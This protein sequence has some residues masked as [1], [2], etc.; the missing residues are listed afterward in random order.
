MFNY[1]DC[2]AMFDDFGREKVML[3]RLL[4]G[5]PWWGSWRKKQIWKERIQWLEKIKEPRLWLLYLMA[6]R[7]RILQQ[8][9]IKMMVRFREKSL[10]KHADTDYLP[11]QI[12]PMMLTT[13]VND[14]STDGERHLTPDEV[15][16]ELKDYKKRLQAK[17]GAKTLQEVLAMYLTNSE[18]ERKDS[19]KFSIVKKRLR[20]LHCRKRCRSEK[21]FYLTIPQGYDT[22]HARS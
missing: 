1:S 2:K 16:A 14:T 6:R 15:A 7:R 9:V 13:Q 4:D 21:L 19:A 22:S 11:L 12:L 5:L 10:S 20:F 3:Q 8:A 17:F 18:Q